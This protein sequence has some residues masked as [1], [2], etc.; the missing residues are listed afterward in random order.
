MGKTEELMRVAQ[1]LRTVPVTGEYWAIMEACVNS[2]LKIAEQLR[3]EENAVN[4][5]P[6]A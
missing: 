3:G 5:K 2:C 1:L 6:D 4:N